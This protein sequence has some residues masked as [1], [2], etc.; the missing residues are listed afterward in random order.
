MEEEKNGVNVWSRALSCLLSEYPCIQKQSS[1][2]ALVLVM[3]R[4]YTVLLTLACSL[5]QP[6]LVASGG[7]MVI[8]KSLIS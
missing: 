5:A 7:R 2:H 3:Q 8:F 4:N 1:S 6:A